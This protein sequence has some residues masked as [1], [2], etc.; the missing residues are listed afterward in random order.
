MINRTIERKSTIRISG[1]L[2]RLILAAIVVLE[3]HI[4]RAIFDFCEAPMVSRVRKDAGSRL[5][6][7]QESDDRI[8]LG[9]VLHLRQDHGIRSNHIHLLSFG[10]SQGLSIRSIIIE[11][12]IRNLLG[13]DANG[14]LLLMFEASGDGVHDN[15]LP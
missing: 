10:P 14:D 8:I 2:Q 15:L 3:D 7:N 6:F 4:K 13:S 9:S 11:A 5:F 12:E 1:Y